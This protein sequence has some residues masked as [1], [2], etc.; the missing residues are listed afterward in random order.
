[1]AAPIY[2]D[3][4]ATTPVHP[5]VLQRMLPFFSQDFGN[6]ASR[7][8]AWG[9]RAAEAVEAAR[10]QTAALIGAAPHDIVFTSGATE[11]INLALKG[12][13]EVYGRQRRRIVTVSTEHR[14]VLDT[15]KR[16]EASGAEVVV[17][18][19]QADGMLDTDALRSVVDGN[20]LLVAVMMANN[21]TGVVQPLRDVSSIAHAHGAFLFS[22]TTQAAGKVRIDVDE[23]GIDLCCVSAHKLYGPKGAGALFV[24]RKN[25]RVAVAAQL[26][27]GGHENGRRSGTLNV[28]GI[29][30]LGAAAE[31]AAREWWSDA[32][33]ISVL[34]TRLEQGLLDLG[35]VTV[36]GNT[37]YRLPNTTNLCFTGHP[38]AGMIRKL[39][40]L[41]VSAGSACSSALPEPSHVLKAMGLTDE[42]SASSLRFSLG[43]MTTEDEVV[44][45]VGS[46]RSALSG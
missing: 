15:C 28:P 32:E 23:E 36:N 37:R 11:S 5:D 43:K 46:V 4:N 35:G 30:G 7:T 42:E 6:A 2:L 38:V 13:F 3:Y 14:A 44:D 1:L 10:E 45:A 21:E 40:G 17:V 39:G 8:H 16:L 9:W 24:R 25:P 22:D 41:G 34:R 31:L 29:V 18:P 12:V 33:R 26:H 20:T 27:G 19:V